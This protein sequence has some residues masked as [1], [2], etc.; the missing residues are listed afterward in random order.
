LRAKRAEFRCI[1]SMTS[2]WGASD[3]SLRSGHACDADLRM[4]AQDGLVLGKAG[5]ANRQAPSHLLIVSQRTP[6]VHERHRK[7]TV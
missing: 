5:Q 3:H 6:L 1:P 7:V 4:F 2:L